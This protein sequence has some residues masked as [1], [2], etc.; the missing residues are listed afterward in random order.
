ML[1]SQ[2]FG[3]DLWL[4]SGHLSWRV[5][6]RVQR[7]TFQNLKPTSTARPRP[8]QHWMI[9]KSRVA[10]VLASL[11]FSTL[12]MDNNHRSSLLLRGHFLLQDE[13]LPVQSTVR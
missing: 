7:Q 10:V 1:V 13:R 4:A 5:C 6:L 2:T 9:R 12:I 11:Q 3:F 8:P